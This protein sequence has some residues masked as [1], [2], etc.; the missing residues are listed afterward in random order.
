MSLIEVAKNL[1]EKK[2]EKVLVQNGMGSCVSNSKRRSS[3]KDL[4]A[5]QIGR[6]SLCPDQGQANSPTDVIAFKVMIETNE[7]MFK[8]LGNVYKMDRKVA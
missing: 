1:R 6:R 3:H 7:K 2:T 4:G 5:G 8:S